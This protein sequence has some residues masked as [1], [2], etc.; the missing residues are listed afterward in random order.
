MGGS[1]EPEYDDSG[2]KEAAAAGPPCPASLSPDAPITELTGVGE[3]IASRL[4]TV[5]VATVFDLVTFFPRRYRA[6]RE[7]AAPDEQSIGELVRMSGEVSAVRLQW[8]PGRRAMVTIS[9]QC[10][11]GST[12]GAAFFNQP[13]LRKSY[14]VGQRR[15][16]EGTLQKKGKRFALAAAKV[17]PVGAVADGEVQLRY[18]EVEGVSTARMQKWIKLVLDQLDWQRVTLPELPPGIEE[19]ELSPQQLLLAMHRPADVGAHE[20]A[21]RHF[22]VREAIKLFESVERARRSRQQRAAATYEVDAALAG[23]ILERFPFALTE[24]QDQAVRSLWRRLSG[25]GAMGVLLQ[26]DVGT[27]KT[28]VAIAASLAVCAKG[29]LV[30]FLAPTELLAE[31]HYA[32]VSKWLKGTGVDVALCTATHKRQL[33]SSGPR[34]VFGTHALLT[35]D[36]QLPGLG[37]VVVDEQHRFGVRQRMQLVHKGDNP[38]VLVMTATPIPRTMAL[39]LFGD[40]DVVTLTSR[41]ARRTA[42]RAFH[43]PTEK[44][45][46]VIRS[47]ERAVRREGRVFVV[48]PAVGEEGEKGGVMRV[49]EALQKKFRCALVH[50]RV[51]ASER[52]RALALFREGVV[53]VLVGTTV[54]E[55][56]LDVPQATLVVIVAADRFGIATLHQVRGRVGRGQRRGIALLCGPKTE[57][58][59]AVC[60]TTNGFELAERDLALRGSGELLGTQQSGFSELRALDPIEDLDVLLQVRKAVR[61]EDSDDR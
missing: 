61:G 26:G 21:R 43:V 30:A 12:F 38:H 52:Q 39:A 19:L 57:R 53:D 4:A 47:I 54:L 51:K 59:E 18:P 55:V 27:G 7:L 31:Q 25:P 36:E 15:D 24:D 35:A 33:P 20:H 56:G 28:A 11:D 3:S 8:L 41:P 9:F 42:V 37:L 10:D 58:V 14:P 32:S 46:R 44:W 49:H 23:R 17:L 6:L 40:L 45:A 22:A 60:A 16:V 50:G 2:A 13:W 34:I 29:A 48:C 1:V 5:S